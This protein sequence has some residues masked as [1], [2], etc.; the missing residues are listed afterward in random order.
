[1]I[2]YIRDKKDNDIVDIELFRYYDRGLDTKI[3]D[4]RC[5]VNIKNYTKKYTEL[6]KNPTLADLFTNTIYELSQIREYVHSN[7]KDDEVDSKKQII[8]A[9]RMILRDVAEKFNLKLV[10]D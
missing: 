9:L 7:K 5:Y 4:C 10:E 6:L 8:G 2:F 1:M 3:I